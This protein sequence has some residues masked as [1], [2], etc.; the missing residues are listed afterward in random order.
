MRPGPRDGW[1]FIDVVVG[2]T[3]V[4]MLGAMLGVAAT[5]QQRSMKRL[6]DTRAAYRLAEAAML[7][8]SGGHPMAVGS[9]LS[10]RKM[11]DSPRV[12]GMD[13]IEIRATVNG[14]AARLVGLVPAGGGQ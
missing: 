3:L 9:S 6:D 11:Q 2:M 5:M 4:A 14:S 10:V 7:S 12:P 13:W 1:V 8:M